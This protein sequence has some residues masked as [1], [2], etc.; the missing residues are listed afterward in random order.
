M[1]KKTITIKASPA[2]LNSVGFVLIPVSTQ[3][4]IS[5]SLYLRTIRETITICLS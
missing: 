3:K 1:K 4:V 5:E 2:I